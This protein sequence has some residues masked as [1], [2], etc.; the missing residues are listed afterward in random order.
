ML[1]K[2]TVI[3]WLFAT[4]T[5]LCA[6]LGGESAYNFLKINPSAKSA[7]L[8]GVAVASM[9]NDISMV[10]QNPALLDSS[11]HRKVSLTYLGYL[12][13][14]SHSSLA[15]AWHRN[16]IGTLGVSLVSLDY[17]SFTS[18]DE[19]NVPLANF[20]ANEFAVGLLYSRSVW[21]GV[22]LGAELNTI[23]S[24]LERYRSYGMALNVGARYQSPDRLLNATLTFK[25][26]GFQLKPYTEG[27]TQKLPF[28]V[29][30]AV[31]KK[32]EK[33]PF[34]IS[35]SLNDLQSFSVYNNTDEQY[36]SFDGSTQTKST[37]SKIG[38]ELMS[39]VAV[40]VQVIPSKYFFVMGGYSFRRR[41]ELKV[42]ESNG[43]TGF[44][45]G[46]GIRLKYFELN[47]GRAAYHAGQGSN[48]IGLIVKL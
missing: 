28:E 9:H 45:F 39:H 26:V 36:R 40:G 23:I 3:L 15:A 20:N 16:D 4:P 22:N 32:F 18:T 24:Q 38:S 14:I 11:M 42:G 47:Y 25:N 7:A 41:N 46:F 1:K 10:A 21:Y 31:A 44:S 5:L 12:A 6:Q 27:N 48:H 30:L 37:L 33:A 13:G 17:G 2:T 34:G 19:E 29:Q 43:A 35:L 8:G